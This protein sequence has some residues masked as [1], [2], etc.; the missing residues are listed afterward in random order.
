[1]SLKRGVRQALLSTSFDIGQLS[2]LFSIDAARS[3]ITLNSGN[4][5]QINRLYPSNVSDASQGTALN[6]PLY[7]AT[8]FNGFPCISFDGTNDQLD[9]SVPQSFGQEVFVVL[10]TTNVGLSDRSLLNRSITIAPFPPALY[11]GGNPV[12]AGV[13]QAPSIFWGTAHTLTT[14]VISRK[15]I[16]RFAINAST[17]ELQVDGNTVYSNTHALTALSTWTSICLSTV[18]QA[19]ILLKELHIIPAANLTAD[20]RNK[21]HADLALRSGLTSLLPNSNP[22]KNRSRIPK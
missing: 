3:A 17:V 2:P 9:I 7:Q 20:I 5:S 16:L 15:C 19:K 10:D 21:I 8:G 1:M 22:Y 11:V 4:V 12:S 6:Q 13:N 14:T 18:Q